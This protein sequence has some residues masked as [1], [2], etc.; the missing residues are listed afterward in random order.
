MFRVFSLQCASKCAAI[1]LLALPAK[2]ALG[3]PVSVGN[4]PETVELLFNWPDGFVAEYDVHFGAKPSDT[5]DVY[6]ASQAAAADPNLSLNWEYFTTFGYSLNVASYAGGHIGDGSVYN[7]L[8]PNNYWAEWINTGAGWTLGNGA[9][10]DFVG[11][12]DQIGWVFGSTAP[13]V[14]EPA[15]LALL[16]A[17]AVILL[18][19]R[20]RGKLAVGLM[21][22]TGALLISSPSH[23][24]DSVTVV[25]GTLAQ[26]TVEASLGSGTSYDVETNNLGDWPPTTG[27]TS[28]D[29]DAIGLSNPDFNASAYGGNPSTIIA[30]GNGGGVT[31]QFAAPVIPHAG[32]KDLGIFTAQALSGA[33]GGFFNGNMEAAILVSKDDLNWYTLDGTIVASPTTYNATAYS[34]NVPTLAYDFGTDAAAWSDGY[35][36]TSLANLGLLSIADYTTPMPDDHLFNGASST[37]AERLALETDSSAAD[38]AESFGD[39]GGGNWFDLSGSGLTQVNYVRLNGDANDPSSG[40]V[41]LD[42][43]FANAD[44]VPEPLGAGFLAMC[45]ALALRRRRLRKLTGITQSLGS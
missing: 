2:M 7:P 26:G 9:S 41:R 23:A 10:A 11:A 18:A 40:G 39:S 25:P 19:F 29:T 3:A 43:V 45:G 12:G 15:S 34:L 1:C 27:G 38:Y 35:P 17:P 8:E 20:K 28:T 16:V 13:P 14:P 37:N 24:A 33:T 21:A 6:D 4:G 44:A 5:I 31:L 32:E 22:T 30:F 42:A 36:G